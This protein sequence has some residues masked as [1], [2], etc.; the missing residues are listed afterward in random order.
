MTG[1]HLDIRPTLASTTLTKTVETTKGTDTSRHEQPTVPDAASTEPAHADTRPAEVR[2]L[3][4]DRFGLN[5]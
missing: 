3:L 5:G 1:P 4:R 2:A